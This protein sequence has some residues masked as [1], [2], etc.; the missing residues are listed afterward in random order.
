MKSMYSRLLSCNAG[1]D[2]EE[3][4]VAAWAQQSARL[5]EAFERYIMS[6]RG[7]S[8]S[9]ETN[10]ERQFLRLYNEL[11]TKEPDC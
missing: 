2:P 3:A 11:S 10:L 7:P 9:S 1:T 5:I 8:P 6:S 4:A